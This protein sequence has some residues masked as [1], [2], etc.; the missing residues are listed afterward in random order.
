[1]L[2]KKLS[3][4]VLGKYKK[5]KAKKKSV[6]ETERA[7]AEEAKRC[8]MALAVAAEVQEQNASFISLD[9]ISSCDLSLASTKDFRCWLRTT[10]KMIFS[11]RVV[12]KVLNLYFSKTRIC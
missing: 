8:A 10:W 1:M 2:C 4:K 7:A 5:R 9:D 3:F 6:E 11:L 12:M